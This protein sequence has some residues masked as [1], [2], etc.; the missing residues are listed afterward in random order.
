MQ[1][2]DGKFIPCSKMDY[3]IACTDE[4]PERWLRYAERM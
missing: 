1:T 4:I 3:I 2:F